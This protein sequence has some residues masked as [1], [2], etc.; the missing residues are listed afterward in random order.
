MTV[1]DTLLPPVA[2]REAVPSHRQAPLEPQPAHEADDQW[3]D[4]VAEALA[5]ASR[6]TA[7]VRKP[8]DATPLGVPRVA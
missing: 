1:A 8:V 4:P 2:S 6:I 5:F 3:D 7:Q